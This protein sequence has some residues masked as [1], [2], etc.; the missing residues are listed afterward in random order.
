MVRGTTP[1]HVFVL[2]FGSEMIQRLEITYAQ[3]GA[4]K[5][6]KAD[7]DCSINGNTVSCK[8][9]QEETFSFSDGSNVEIQI[10]VMTPGSD[11]LASGI[12]L[13]GVEECLSNEVLQ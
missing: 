10:R 5:L 11:V 7:S 12:M 8:L 2:P 13:V 6:M 4:V 3:N 9:T 1:E